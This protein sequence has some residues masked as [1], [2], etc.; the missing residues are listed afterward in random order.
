VW[1][2]FAES[3]LEP[4]ARYGVNV[5]LVGRARVPS[6]EMAQAPSLEMAR[7]R[8]TLLLDDER[9]DWESDLAGGLNELADFLAA[10]LATS[11]D[12]SRRIL[13]QVRGVGDLDDYGRVSNYIGGLDV[14]EGFAV[15]R[16]AE[17]EVI[18]SLNVRGDMNRLKRAIAL[19]R[20]LRIVEDR[21]DVDGDSQPMFNVAAESLL[22]QL[23][24][25][26]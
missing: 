19:R 7:V 22:Y 10:R 17:N 26:R 12:A 5:V 23:V 11:I 25:K 9:Y 24:P 13:L 1:G 21:P 20:V 16:V 8:W 2:G 18:F 6:F 4:S 3:L 15:D 14:V